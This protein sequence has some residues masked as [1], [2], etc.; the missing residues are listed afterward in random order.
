MGLFGKKP[1][2]KEIEKRWQEAYRA[3][4]HVYEKDDGSILVSFALTED[5]D[6]IFPLEP[7]KQWDIKGKEISLWMITMV[8][9]TNP[10]GGIIGQMEYHEAIKRLK[11]YMIASADNW[12]MIMAMTH[13]ELDSLFEGLPRSLV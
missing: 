11:P 5:T 8:S 1:N 4:P 12:T 13:K 7:E 6:S 2:K 9:L 10:E 3:N